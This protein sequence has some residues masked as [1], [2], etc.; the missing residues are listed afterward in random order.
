[1]ILINPQIEQFKDKKGE[2]HGKTEELFPFLY[3]HGKRRKDID[4]RWDEKGEN[5]IVQTDLKSGRLIA[6]E[7]KYALIA[8]REKAQMEILNARIRI[9]RID[10]MLSETIAE[11][12]QNRKP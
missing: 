9:E 6:T 12:E 2:I 11:N 7:I 4:I 5:L 8:E 10:E 1:M 3:F